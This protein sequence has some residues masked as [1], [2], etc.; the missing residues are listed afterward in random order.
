MLFKG[1]V[2]SP[3]GVPEGAEPESPPADPM[4]GLGNSPYIQ[5]AEPESS[6][7]E[8]EVP[9]SAPA[10]EKIGFDNPKHPDH[11]RFVELQEKAKQNDA[12]A[13]YYKQ[14]AEQALQLAQ[15]PEQEPPNV[16][17]V[18][19]LLNLVKKTVQDSV[20]PIQQSTAQ[21]R[22]AAMEDQMRSKHEDY[23][24]V[25]NKMLADDPDTV[26]SIMQSSR[27]PAQVVYRM[28]KASD[29]DKLIKD[30]EERGKQSV[31]NVRE[32][33][34]R[35]PIAAA[36]TPKQTQ[37][38]SDRAKIAQA[39]QRGELPEDAILGVLGNSPYLEE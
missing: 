5:D 16:E 23:D 29:I 20:T 26:Q 1:L 35:T 18:D 38:R 36:T 14:L 8:P 34:S 2:Y 22:L 21:M 15:Q 24:D 6:P 7:A 13:Q 9:E 19:D 30:A 3:D 25:V 33:R 4:D 39:V 17:T 31:L 12:Q 32:E 28:G 27:N 37:T 10:E 11:A